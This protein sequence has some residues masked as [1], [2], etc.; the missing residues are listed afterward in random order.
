LYTEIYADRGS[1]RVTGDLNPVVTGLV[2][3]QTGLPQVSSPAY[4]KQA[5]EVFATEIVVTEGMSHPEAFIRVRALSLWQE[6]RNGAAALIR[7]MI[8]GPAALDSLD[9]IGQAR[10][11]AATR[12]LLEYLLRP[13]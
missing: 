6:Q 12:G 13:K 7:E 8:E 9:V 11:A 3:L 4:L 5:E 10:V 2:K 1:L